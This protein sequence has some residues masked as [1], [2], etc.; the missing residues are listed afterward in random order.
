MILTETR[1]STDSYWYI[2]TGQSSKVW[3]QT[4]GCS[5]FLKHTFCYY[6]TKKSSILHFFFSIPSFSHILSIY[7]LIILLTLLLEVIL[8]ISPQT[9]YYLFPTMRPMVM[10][11][12]RSILGSMAVHG[13]MSA[14]AVARRTCN[15]RCSA[16][17]WS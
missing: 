7:T 16:D 6:L 4:L 17:Q 15:E 11:S 9:L 5:D 2:G 8:H 10:M 12:S 1:L 14:A 3:F 13:R